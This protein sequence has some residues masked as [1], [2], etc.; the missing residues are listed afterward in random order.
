M[1]KIALCEDVSAHA[2][3]VERLLEI[4]QK[5]RPGIEF[6][7]DI[8][9]ASEELLKS[10]ENKD[11][12]DIYL[13][14]IMMAPPDGITLARKIRELN[15]AVPLIFLTHSEDFAMDAFR[16]SAMQYILKPVCKD[17]LFAALDKIIAERVVDKDKFFT[18][19]APGRAVTLLHSSI[20]LVEKSGRCLHFH[21]EGGEV[22]ASKAVRISFDQ[23]LSGLLS[24]ARFLRVHQSF[25][26]NMEHVRVLQNAMMIM[27]NGQ[28]I[29]IPRPKL[30]SV[31]RIY[32]KFIKD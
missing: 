17:T 7:L 16:V 1:I 21:L 4:Y 14:D 20:I 23:A 19:A 31:K 15:N 27:T 11:A 32:A 10:F 6:E 12:Y 30:A 24:D 9:T 3:A 5:E 8:F 2:K 13:L 28:Q 22:V 25:A 26:V 18:I 29:A